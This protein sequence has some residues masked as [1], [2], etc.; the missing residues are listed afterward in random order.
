VQAFDLDFELGSGAGTKAVFEVHQVTNPFGTAE[1]IKAV[2][3]LPEGFEPRLESL[4]GRPVEFA[5]RLDKVKGLMRELIL[6]DGELT[7]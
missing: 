2:V 6:L 7:G 5:G 3:R 1:P 4:K